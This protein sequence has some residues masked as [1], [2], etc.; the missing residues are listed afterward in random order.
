MQ[1][2]MLGGMP[3]PGASQPP[4]VFEMIAADVQPVYALVRK[5]QQQQMAAWRWP[6]AARVTTT[7]LAA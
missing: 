2:A 5:A 3:F 6:R 7:T 1:A 4:A